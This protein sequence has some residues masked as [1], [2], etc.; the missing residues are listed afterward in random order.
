MRVV[1]LEDEPIWAQEVG[2]VVRHHGW[3]LRWFD[4]IARFDAGFDPHDTDVL[5]LDIHMAGVDGDGLDLLQR[6]RSAGVATPV[7]M[8]TAFPAH[9]EPEALRNGADTYLL[10]PFDPAV[11]AERLKVLI[12]RFGAGDPS[13]MTIGLLAVSSD[14]ETAWWASRPL[15]LTPQSFAILVRL[16]HAHGAV[17]DPTTLWRGAW[18]NEH[19]GVRMPLLHVAIT[20]LRAELADAIGSK[21]LIVT[22]PR[23]GYRI[24]PD[25]ASCR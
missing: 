10:K 17:V 3:R 18:P 11:L 13:R 6:L 14:R 7:L 21:Q 1:L 9:R 5:V 2:D 25:A 8:L 22:V 19:H 20:R 12:R 15:P 16:V 4:T 24:D 23:R